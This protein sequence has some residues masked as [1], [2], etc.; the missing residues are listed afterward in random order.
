[1]KRICGI[2]ENDLRNHEDI[3]DKVYEEDCQKDFYFTQKDRFQSYLSYLYYFDS[4][5]MKKLLKE[6]DYREAF[7]ES[8]TQ[9][10]LL[11]QNKKYSCKELKEIIAKKLAK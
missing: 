7:E 6:Y 5:K 1:M 11:D 3:Y 8:I 2:Y 4:R 9:I 10:C